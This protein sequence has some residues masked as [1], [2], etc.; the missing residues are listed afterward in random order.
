MPLME[1]TAVR[2]AGD[3]VWRK[4][5]NRFSHRKL[6]QPDNSSASRAPP[7]NRL[8]R[9]SNQA[10]SWP[11]PSNTNTGAA[12]SIAENRLPRKTT[13][14]SPAKPLPVTMGT[15]APALVADTSNEQSL[16]TSA[17]FEN[18][19]A[20]PSRSRKATPDNSSREFSTRIAAVS[21][22]TK[23]MFTWDNLFGWVESIHR[24]PRHR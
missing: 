23:E 13:G 6:L 11:W 10:P 12:R 7:E 8:P 19:S 15:A 22:A 5:W 4:F 20:E 1:T 21:A 18:P 16:A 24:I 3:S 2:L 17:E 14:L 9:S